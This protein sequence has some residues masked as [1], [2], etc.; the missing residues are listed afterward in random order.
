[1]NVAILV[2]LNNNRKEIKSDK[3]ELKLTDYKICS[4]TK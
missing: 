3:N 4:L 2:F 1:M